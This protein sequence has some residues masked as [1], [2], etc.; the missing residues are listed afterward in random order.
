MCVLVCFEASQE[1]PAVRRKMPCGA[2]FTETLKA[3]NAL[4]LECLDC[5]VA[6]GHVEADDSPKF[7]VGQFAGFCEIADMA[8]RATITGGNPLF[9]CPITVCFYCRLHPLKVAPFQAFVKC[10]VVPLSGRL[11]LAKVRF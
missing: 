4:D 1:R 2:L 5:P 7:D 8:Q 10:F 11:G 6:V 3:A 9:I